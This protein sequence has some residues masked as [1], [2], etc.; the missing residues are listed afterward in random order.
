MPHT[1]CGKMGEYTECVSLTINGRVEDID[2]CIA[3]IVRALNEGGVATIASCCG[4]G[5]MPGIISLAD[6]RHLMVAPKPP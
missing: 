6:G 1:S 5:H 4:H 2:R 3:P